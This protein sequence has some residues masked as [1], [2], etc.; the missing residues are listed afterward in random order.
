MSTRA[1]ALFFAAL[2]V[3]HTTFAADT[4]PETKPLGEGGLIYTPPPD[5]TWQPHNKWS[6][7]LAYYVARGHDGV[8]VMK[9]AAD[10]EIVAGT[11]EGLVKQL[12]AANLKA[13]TKVLME[14]TVEEDVRFALKIHE[15][16]E[17][18]TGDKKK[19]SEQ[20]HLYRYAGKVVVMETVNT[21]AAD[22]ETA[23]A[24]LSAGEDMLLSLTGPGV[25][26]PR[27]V[28]TRPATKPSAS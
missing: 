10:M 27:K 12:K 23:K 26:P 17:V 9:I 7:G 25:K 16:V 18:G 20:L 8:M 1:I 22:P 11:S 4:A 19:I 24:E 13:K 6:A 2:F 14:P 3:V 28:P 15:R 21:V 5:A